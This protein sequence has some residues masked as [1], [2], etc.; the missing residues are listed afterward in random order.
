[1]SKQMRKL[2]MSKLFSFCLIAIAVMFI[3]M[4]DKNT[5]NAADIP[6]YNINDSS[7]TIISNGD[8][9]IEGD[10]IATQNNITINGGLNNVNMDC[11]Q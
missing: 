6:T 5:V 4:L 10:G 2:K 11:Q 1:M 7:V 9:I 8:Y 3:G